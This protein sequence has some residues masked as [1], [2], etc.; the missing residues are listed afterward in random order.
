MKL[1][2]FKIGERVIA[3]VDLHTESGKP[4]PAGTEIELVAFPAKTFAAKPTDCTGD[5]YVDSKQ[6][7]YNAVHPN[8]PKDRIR[9]NFCTIR[10]KRKGEGEMP[11]HR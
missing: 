4:I 1:Y 10:R 6:F 3:V 2:G 5:K 9:A 11:E 8:D 7:F